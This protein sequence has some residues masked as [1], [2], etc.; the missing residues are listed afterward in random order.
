MAHIN[1]GGKAS[2]MDKLIFDDH[3]IH[4]LNILGENLPLLTMCLRG[5]ER[6]CLRVTKNG[7]L[8]LTP[9]PK[10]LGSALTNELI[11]TIILNH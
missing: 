5:I 8:A 9:H 6:E 7:K 1:S 3:Y 4:R 2:Y 10:T 11:T